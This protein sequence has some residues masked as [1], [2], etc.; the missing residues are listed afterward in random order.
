MTPPANPNQIR[1]DIEEAL[2]KKTQENDQQ[3]IVTCDA[4]PTSDALTEAAKESKERQQQRYPSLTC[5]IGGGFGQKY[6]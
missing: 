3:Y 5:W 2:R 1:L 4:S 6:C